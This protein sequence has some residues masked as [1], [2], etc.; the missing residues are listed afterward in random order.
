MWTLLTDINIGFCQKDQ[1]CAILKSGSV[2]CCLN[3]QTLS[4]C[5][6]EAKDATVAGGSSTSAA[7]SESS[8]VSPKDTKTPT[9]TETKGKQTPG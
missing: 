9:T 5:D 3:N 2:T 1:Y 6:A 8:S 7:A 4:E